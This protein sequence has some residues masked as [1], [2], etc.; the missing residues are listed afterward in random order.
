MG[1]WG[2]AVHVLRYAKGSAQRGITHRAAD[3]MTG[4]THAP[5]V[6]GPDN[7][8]TSG[9]VFTLYGGAVAW[10]SKLQSVAAPW[11]PEADIYASC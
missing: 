7:K 5:Y 1:H 3:E 10:G 8:S 2:A 11:T 6:K 4:W 9:W